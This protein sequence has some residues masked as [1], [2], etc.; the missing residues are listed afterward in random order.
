[1]NEPGQLQVAL[2]LTPGLLEL[3]THNEHLSHQ[4]NCL[5]YLTLR[6]HRKMC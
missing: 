2:W 4:H 3:V 1:M 5:C 6:Q